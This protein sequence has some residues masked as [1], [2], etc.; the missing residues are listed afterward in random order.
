MSAPRQ[1][2]SLCFCLMA[3]VA[4]LAQPAQL[5][6]QESSEAL[7]K[8]LAE[9]LSDEALTIKLDRRPGGS[10]PVVGGEGR[11]GDAK[12]AAVP[13]KPAVPAARSPA[14][15][16][17]GEGGPAFWGELKPEY[18]LCSKGQR[19]SPID[20]RPSFTVALE[21]IEFDYKPL[22][23]TVQDSGHALEATPQGSAGIRVAGRRWELKHIHLHHPGE[24]RVNG[25]SFNLSVH[26]VHKDA[27]GRLAV[28]SLLGE[29]GMAQPVLQSMLDA[30]PLEKGQAQATAQAVDLAQLLPQRRGYY[31]YMGSLTTPP[32]TEGV[33]WLVMQEPV[34]VSLLQLDM[35]ARLY[36]MNARP[37][38]PTAGR[39]V[40]GAM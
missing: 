33:L 2:P 1:R 34:T 9:R 40:K 25:R 13:A 10:A 17:E 6:A 35:I 23:L 36:P 21:P 20:I 38:Q 4:L 24:E 22:V 14:W 15:S 11:H 16:Y 26:L 30:L 31:T 5:W 19:Q 39:I 7:K 28:V 29:A 27:Q 12:R 8:R 18:A 32:C 37:I 3:W